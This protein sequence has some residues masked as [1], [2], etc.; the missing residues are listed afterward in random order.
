MVIVLGA[1]NFRRRAP[2][3]V[4]FFRTCVRALICRDGLDTGR[5]EPLV[6]LLY[7]D[8]RS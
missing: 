6:L 5:L 2:V 1:E 4:S 8:V 3:L 7:R